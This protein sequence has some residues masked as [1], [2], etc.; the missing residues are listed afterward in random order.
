[1]QHDLL[2]AAK[3]PD[4]LA[5]A[6]RLVSFLWPANRWAQSEAIDALKGCGK[7]AWRVVR[8]LLTQEEYFT[9]HHELVFVAMEVAGTEA[10]GELERIVRE[11]TQY[12]YWVVKSGETPVTGNPPMHCH[13]SRLSGSLNVLKRLG[14]RDSEGIVAKLRTEWDADPRLAHLGS[15]GDKGRSPILEYAD[16]ILKP[17]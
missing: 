15:G 5:R 11:E 1:V 13:Y 8:R 12:W 3:D 17:R 7:P 14:Y 10:F 2:A 6:E 16:E 4:P 9:I